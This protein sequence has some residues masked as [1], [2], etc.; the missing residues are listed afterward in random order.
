MYEASKE[1][2]EFA[3]TQRVLLESKIDQAKAEADARTDE[4]ARLV[5]DLEAAQAGLGLAYPFRTKNLAPR[6]D[7]PE[8]ALARALTSDVMAAKLMAV[9]AGRRLDDLQ[10]DYRMMQ[11]TQT[12][13]LPFNSRR[14]TAEGLQ[15]LSDR[16]SEA[17][18]AE[19]QYTEDN[20]R[21][22]CSGAGIQGLETIPSHSTVLK[23]GM[24][25]A[26]GDEPWAPNRRL[27]EKELQLEASKEALKQRYADLGV[28]QMPPWVQPVA[29]AGGLTH[30]QAMFVGEANN[31][32]TQAPVAFNC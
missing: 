9:Q 17:A 29:P 18:A 6:Q 20:D 11:K 7:A 16:Q 3:T 2:F 32:H 4:Y 13:V 28:G 15:E 26:R 27:I 8:E 19:R 21:F 24:P 14:R 22:R 31:Y 10:V 1:G 12:Q 5:A 30:D 25:V 23:S